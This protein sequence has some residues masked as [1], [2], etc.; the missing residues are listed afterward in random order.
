MS[1]QAGEGDVEEVEVVAKDAVVQDRPLKNSLR[2][3]HSHLVQPSLGIP[4][5][6]LLLDPT[7]YQSFLVALRLI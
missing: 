2:V 5:V 6:V 7:S 1:T 4:L 3:G